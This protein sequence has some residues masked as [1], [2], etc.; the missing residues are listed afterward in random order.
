MISWILSNYHLLIPAVSVIVITVV[1]VAI[2]IFCCRRRRQRKLKSSSLQCSN[3]LNDQNHY[4]LRSVMN[5]KGENPQ[6]G[7]NNEANKDKVVKVVVPMPHTEQSNRKYSVNIS[8]NSQT[9]GENSMC[10]ATDPETEV[11]NDECVSPQAPC[12]LHEVDVEPNVA[13]GYLQT[14]SSPEYENPQRLF[15]QQI[16]PRPSSELQSVEAYAVTTLT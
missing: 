3:P 9:V 4:Q 2:A 15:G 10:V 14:P 7:R 8:R 13:Y 12:D 16:R 11:E 1:I 6:L 5:R